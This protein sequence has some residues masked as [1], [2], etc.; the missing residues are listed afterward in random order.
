ML[1]ALAN[2]VIAA[3][4]LPGVLSASCETA[5]AISISDAP[6]KHNDFSLQYI[7]PELRFY[8]II[9]PPPY[10]VRGSLTVCVRTHRASCNERSASS[11]I[12]FVAP[13]MTIVQAS[14]I[15]QPEK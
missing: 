12:C 14:F 8:R 11:R 4:S 5:L 3:D 2:E 9:V 10:T 7:V 6:T 15:A 13:L 1:N